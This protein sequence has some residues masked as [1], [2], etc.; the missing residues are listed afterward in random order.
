MIVENDSRIVLKEYSYNHLFIIFIIYFNDLNQVIK[1]LIANTPLKK[2]KYTL[3][4]PESNGWKLRPL[5]NS[6]ARL[7]LD[8]TRKTLLNRIFFFFSFLGGETHIFKTLQ[9]NNEM[10]NT[11]I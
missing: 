10:Y 6:L 2:I 1:I 11:W 5:G 7:L 9:V 4:N 8:K 3:E